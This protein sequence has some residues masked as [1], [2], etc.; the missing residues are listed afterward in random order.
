MNPIAKLWY[1]GL[2]YA[3]VSFWQVHSFV[4]RRNPADYLTD[5]AT[6]DP[7]LLLP[8]IYETWQF[9]RPLA[10][11]ARAN[12]HPVHVVTPL[13]RNAATV[14]ASAQL[15][16]DY[17]TNHNLTRVTIVAHSKGGLIGKYVMVLLDAERRISRMIAISTPFSGSIYARLFFIPSIRAFS[18]RDKTTL[19]LAANLEVNSRITSIYGVFDPHIPGGSELGGATNI[20]LDTAGHFRIIADKTLLQTVDRILGDPI[21]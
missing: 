4:F 6:K 12:G 17:I 1:W 10:D 11:R 19:M 7:I 15:V 14:A 3:Y 18:P 8:G 2:D 21:S 20:R 9:M 13:G 16:A 5:A